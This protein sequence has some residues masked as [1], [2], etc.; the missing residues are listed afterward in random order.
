MHKKIERKI[1]PLDEWQ[2]QDLRWKGFRENVCGFPKHFLVGEDE[3]IEVIKEM[4][5]PG[6]H[7]ALCLYADEDGGEVHA[8]RFE[9]T[10]DEKGRA[11][12]KLIEYLNPEPYFDSLVELGVIEYR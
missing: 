8:Y 7:V 1:K 10:K 12:H 2:I 6:R 11:Y 4:Y 9:W 5:F 3:S